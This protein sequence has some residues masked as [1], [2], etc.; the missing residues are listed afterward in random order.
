MDG[1]VTGPVLDMRKLTTK[2]FV[3]RSIRVHGTK[4]TY[5]K[6][7]YQDSSTKITV[8]CPEHGDFKQLPP[9]HVSG[10]GCPKCFI[11]GATPFTTTRFIEKAIQV[12]GLRY[13]YSNVDYKNGRSKVLI[14]CLTHGLFQQQAREHLRGRGCG[15]CNG[16]IKSKMTLTEFIDRACRIHGNKYNYEKVQY[17]NCN[18]K[19]VISCQE[20]GDFLQTPSSHLSGRGCLKCSA[21]NTERFISRAMEIHGNKYDYSQSV[22]KHSLHKIT[23]VCPTHG[24]FTQTASHHLEGR[25]CKLCAIRQSAVTQALSLS[26]FIKRAKEIH[27]DRYSYDDIEYKNAKSKIIIGC[28]KHGSFEMRAYTH[29]EGQGCPTCK[30]SKGELKIENWLR[31]NGIVYE[32]QKKFEGCIGKKYSLRFDFYLPDSNTCIEYDGPQHHFVTTFFTK[33]LALAKQ[34]FLENK[35][36]DGIKNAFCKKNNI[37]LIRLY[38]D[39]IHRSSDTE[40]DKL[41]SGVIWYDY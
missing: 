12:H 35:V 27:G 24:K 9:N 17:T 34:K 15:E 11:P 36:Y 10:H 40:L 2:E 4:Y 3:E 8:T 39:H 22:Y 18:V 33:D 32:T 6:S 31:K 1:T 19:V 14:G 30:K 26:Q 20:H 41:L 25:G 16:T 37:R 28:K 5:A 38:K 23:V 21:I 7:A 13:D 29:L